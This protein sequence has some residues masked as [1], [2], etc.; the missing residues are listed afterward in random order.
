MQTWSRVRGTCTSAGGTAEN[1]AGR[2]FKLDVTGDTRGATY[3]KFFTTAN[4]GDAINLNA[5]KVTVAY[6]TAMP[7]EAHTRLAN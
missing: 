3:P 1:A 6:A 2:G 7:V 5:G 4:D